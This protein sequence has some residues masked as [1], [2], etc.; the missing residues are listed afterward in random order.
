M[1]TIALKY[2]KNISN[3]VKNISDIIP[4]KENQVISLALSKVDNS[5]IRLFSLSKE[6]EIYNEQYNMDIIY[7]CLEGE[8]NIIENGISHVL[9][10]NDL[11]AISLES[12]SH[13]IAN[14]DSI[15]LQIMVKE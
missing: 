5:D 1:E 3:E 10:K 13:V 7:L 6:E 9:N 2:L 15:M 8:I 14:K 4:I 12:K 11:V